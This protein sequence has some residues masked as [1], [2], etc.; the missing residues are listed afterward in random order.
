MEPV[1]ITPFTRSSAIIAEPRM[2]P[3]PGS[4]CNAD[5]GTPASRSNRTAWAAISDVCAAGLANTGLPAASAAATWPVKI[6][7][8]KFQGL[9][10]TTGPKGR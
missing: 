2:R 7:S 9:I 10:Q 5:L 3:L 6:A 4:N 8:G 1:N